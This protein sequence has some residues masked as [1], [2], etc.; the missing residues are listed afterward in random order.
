[1]RNKNKLKYIIVGY[2]NIGHKRH[3]ILGNKVI[4]T[5][6]PNPNAG[7]NYTDVSQIP[8]KILEE[9]DAVVITI[10]RKQKNLSLEFWLNLGKHVLV[11]KPMIITD[12]EVANLS[13]KLK[14]NKVIYYTGYNY[15]FE[16]HIMRIKKII[17]SKSLG[18]LYSAR[19]VY[20][21]GNV[22][23]LKGTWRDTGYGA[24][25]E[26]GCHLIDL[27]MHLFGYSENE[28]EAIKL[29]NFEAKSFD[30]CILSTND[31]KV[32]MEASWIMWKN[33]FTIE[34]YF[35]KGSIH[36][37]G[38]CKWG[39]SD[40]IVRKRIYPAGIPK[41]KLYTISGPPDPTWKSDIKQ[42]EEA[43]RLS[44]NSLYSDLNI[45][46]SLVNILKSHNNNLNAQA[47]IQKLLE[48]PTY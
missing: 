26:V 41:E 8:E 16:P 42:F 11:E 9:I 10:P 25:D 43:I 47:I 45:T 22:A 13:K 40:L 28:F 15:R 20:G 3:D 37:N 6:D 1:M 14:Q 34:A 4:A 46:K 39:K 29:V 32:I 35:E 24:L 36:M 48:N 12:K 2:G 44:K 23:Q 18:K 5:L 31:K 30:H 38:L 27:S 7:A 33:T 17:E 19:L 21:F